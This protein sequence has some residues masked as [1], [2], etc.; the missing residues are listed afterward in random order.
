MAMKKIAFLFLFLVAFAA[1]RD[2]PEPL[3]STSRE[4]EWIVYNTRNSTMPDDQ[5][6]ALVIGKNDVKWIGTSK[7]LLR[8]Q[9]DTWTVY[10]TDN[11]PLP[12]NYVSD[13]SLGSNGT[14]WVGT[15]NGLALFD[16]KRWVVYNK[17]N[18]IMENNT[19]QAIVHDEKRQVTWVGTDD[20]VLKIMDGKSWELMSVGDSHILSMVTDQNG[21]LW[22]GMFKPF[23]FMGQINKY[24]NGA[25]VRYNLHDM[26][27]PSAFPHALAVG[28][29]N[30][31]LSA[32]GGTSVKCLLSIQGDNWTEIVRPVNAFGL[33]S[34]LV[35][36]NKIWVGGTCLS[37]FGTKDA[38][39]ITIPESE[40]HIQDMA[41]DSKGRKW[42]GTLAGGLAGYLETGRH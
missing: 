30:E 29:N 38:A 25:W 40:T 37:L 4:P 32:L 31:I 28:G 7:G 12:S 34:I 6:N 27:Y 10:N 15:D 11:S 1:C 18:S 19:I 2:S 8:I 13:L 14:I 22:V 36:G 26:G 24:H 21:A 9:G 42:L 33:K 5:V 16:G 41:I 3:V 35:E 17:D 39:C 23:V 20:G